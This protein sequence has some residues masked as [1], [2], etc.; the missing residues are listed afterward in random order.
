M[1]VLGISSYAHESSCALI[2]DGRIC[3]LGEEERFNRE[4]HTSKFPEK[5]IRYCLDK[6]KITL[7]DVEAITFFWVPLKEFRDNLSH[8]LR[9][10]PASINLLRAPSGSDDLGFLSRVLAMKNVG[11]ELQSRFHLKRRPELKFIEHHLCHAA[12][13]FLIS[14]FDEAAILTVDGRGE[15]TSTMMSVGK[16]SKIT[17]LREIAV[18]HS[19]GHLYASMTDHLGFKP[20]F[21]EWKVM[22]MSAYGKDTYVK[23]FADMIRFDDD[24]VYR[25]N[26]EYFSFHTHGQTKWLSEKFLAKFGPKR[27]RGDEYTQHYYDLAYA[28]QKLVETAGV[29]LARHMYATTGLPNLCMAGGVVLNCLMNREIVAHTG[30]ENF[31]FQ[32]I[33]NDAGTSLG[34]AL[35]H[36]HSSGDRP[37]DFVFDNVYWGPEFTDDEIE[38]ALQSHAVKYHKTL[39]VAAETARHIADGKIVGW[40][41]GRMES[42][43]RALGNRSIT[44]DP[45]RPDMKDKLNARVKRREGFRPFAPSVLEEKWQEYFTM[46]KNQP[47]PYMILIGD[48]IEGW[49]KKLPAITHVDGTARVHT[50]SRKVNPRYHELISEFEKISGVPVLLNTSFNENEPIVCGPDDAV[51]CFLRTEFDVLAIGNFIAVQTKN[52]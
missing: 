34:S 24:G 22:G 39:H 6:E 49:K 44:T 50:V 2:K 36:Y 20:F 4:K 40:F 12:S 17:K 16:G 33:A 52:W 31:F 23:D 45:T 32:P 15:S 21:D 13:A 35:Y 18:P 8:F 41:Q 43:P 1:Y 25:L 3:A 5:A 47:S 7:A 37:R 30:F 9:Y 26:L 10:L 29:R 51:R 19:L 38:A 46:P 42:G 48:V 28:L 11:R 14:E 27:A